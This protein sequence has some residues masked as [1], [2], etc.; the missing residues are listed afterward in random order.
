VRSTVVDGRSIALT[1]CDG[2]LG[3]LE[4]RC[5]HQGGPVGEGSIENGWL[6]SRFR[7]PEDEYAGGWKVFPAEWPSAEEAAVSS[8]TTS[9][10]TAAIAQ[11]PEQQRLVITMRD[12]HGFSSDEVC[13]ALGL[14]AGNQR[15]LLH[16]A[17]AGVR[18][19]L[20]LLYT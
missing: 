15:V 11:L 10:V 12:V 9:A 7:G 3:A 14:T 1:R 13:D 6:R 19:R 20:E 18:T 4:N 17:R 5:P 16:R 2:R 8:D